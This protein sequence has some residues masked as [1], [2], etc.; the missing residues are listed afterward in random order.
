MPITQSLRNNEKDEVIIKSLKIT[1][2]DR[3]STEISK[4]KITV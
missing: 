2:K 1:A 4:Y 3:K